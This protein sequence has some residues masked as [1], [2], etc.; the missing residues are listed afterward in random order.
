MDVNTAYVQADDDMVAHMTSYLN[1]EL[2]PLPR[3]ESSGD[4]TPPNLRIHRD[5]NGNNVYRRSDNP[6]VVTGIPAVYYGPPG[7]TSQ[8]SPIAIPQQVLRDMRNEEGSN[9]P[10][11]PNV[12]M[13]DLDFVDERGGPRTNIPMRMRRIGG[14]DTFVPI[15]PTIRFTANVRQYLR[16]NFFR[17]LCDSNFIHTTYIIDAPERRTHIHG[18]CYGLRNATNPRIERAFCLHCR[19]RLYRQIIREFERQVIDNTNY[20]KVDGESESD[21]DSETGPN[22][23]S[24]AP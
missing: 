15:S 23:P 9:E 7:G 20:A 22:H 1:R 24:N 3:G 12:R 16:D 11:V 21:D 18:R 6:P 10:L 14:V 13:R 4:D 19:D 2:P 17:F 8:R 5:R